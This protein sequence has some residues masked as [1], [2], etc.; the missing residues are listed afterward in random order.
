MA[1]EGEVGWVQTDDGIWTY[2]DERGAPLTEVWRKSKD[3]WYYLSSDGTILKDRIFEYH[4]AIYYVDETGAMVQNRWVYGINADDTDQEEA[5]YYFAADGKARRNTATRFKW[6]IDGKY[7]IF[8]EEGRLMAGWIDSEGNAVEDDDDP[9]VTGTYYAGPDGALYTNQW[10]DYEDGLWGSDLYSN[11]SDRSYSDYEKLWFYFDSA[12]KKLRSTTDELKK[13]NIN[14]EYYGFDENGVM[15]YWWGTVGTITDADKNRP[16]S[17]SDIKYYSGYDGGQLL[18]NKW[19]W[20]YPSEKLWS[21][22][23]YDQEC[24]WWYTDRNGNV[25]KDKIRQINGKYY[26]FDGIG[27]MQTGFV[28]YNGKSDFA[29]QYDVDNWNAQDFIDGNLYGL[30][31]N[32]LYLFSTDEI[33]D[34]SMQTGTNI[35]V[36]LKD[37]D[38]VFGFAPNGKAYGNRNKLQKKNDSYYING[39]RLD[40]DENFGYGIVRVKDDD[41]V[42]YQVVNTNGRVVE[43]NKK[44]LKDAD[45]GY[46]LILNN[47]FVGY[48]TDEKAPKWRTGEEGTGFYHYDK[49]AKDH[50]QGGLAA[51][52]DTEVITDNLPYEMKL[53]F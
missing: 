39:L 32:D 21:N 38:H 10:L 12:S 7:Y 22:D 2:E 42:Y 28:L 3:K 1:A 19:F 40:A 11:L 8:D 34:G 6:E 48:V 20:M 52:H 17:E 35:V 50:Y 47:R 5:W 23:Y 53:N 14:G 27:R 25:Y 44:V 30:E 37:G 41:E 4:N 15:A 36:E 43:A 13:K 26:A 49:D 16:K 45:G 29:A 51:G 9:F 24:S 18:K 33:N 46:I 31:L